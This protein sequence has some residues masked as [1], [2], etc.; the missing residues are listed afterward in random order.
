MAGPEHLNP[1]Q[2]FHG[3]TAELQ[4]GD[5]LKPNFR[6]S[7]G[8]SADY[9]DPDTGHS[10][11]HDFVWMADR[12]SVARMF[13]R[14]HISDVDF[15]RPDS[16]PA[17]HMYEVEPEGLTHNPPGTWMHPHS[18]VSLAPVRVKRELHPDEWEK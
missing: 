3:T 8:Y 16:S 2:F 10:T 18:Y 4:P 1:T 6:K 9:A 7:G 13:T 17:G 15:D 11:H 14:P 12:P 5:Y